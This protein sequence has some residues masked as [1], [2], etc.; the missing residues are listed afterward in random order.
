MRRKG[1]TISTICGPWCWGTGLRADALPLAVIAVVL[2][3]LIGIIAGT[4][5]RNGGLGDGGGGR[6][7]LG[8]V[9]S[10]PLGSSGNDGDSSGTAGKNLDGEDGQQHSHLMTVDPT[11]L[12][13]ILRRIV[14]SGVTPPHP[15][16]HRLPSQVSIGQVVMAVTA[17]IIGRGRLS[18][19]QRSGSRSAIPAASTPMMSTSSRGMLWRLF[20][21][22]PTGSTRMAMRFWMALTAAAVEARGVAGRSS[23]S[24]MMGRIGSTMVRDHSS[25][26]WTGRRRR[27]REVTGKA[28]QGAGRQ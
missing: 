9:R 4:V 6:Q 7:T 23:S 5:V 12:D 10:E 20:G 17:T 11:W 8:V 27:R 3:A 25:R 19:W 22:V 26:A 18:S 24:S 28:N 1:R 16:P 21:M 13:S 15:I 2:V 14:D